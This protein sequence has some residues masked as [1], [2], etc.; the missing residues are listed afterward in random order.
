MYK[1]RHYPGELEQLQSLPLEGKIRLT[2]LRIRQ[3]LG[4][5]DGEAYISFSGGKDSTVLLHIARKVSPAITAVFCDTGLEYPEIREFVKGFEN[6]VWLKPQMNF[7]QVIDTYGYPIV[8]KETA[9]RIYQIRHYNLTDTYRSKLLGKGL[10][11]IP[12]KWRCLINAP[13]EISHK[14]C[15]I[16]KKRPFHRYEKET[17]KHGINATMASESISRKSSWLLYGCNAFDAKTP[18]SR[19]MS[20]W[21]E[22]DVLEYLIK[23][24]VQYCSLYGDIIGITP[25]GATVSMAELQKMLKELEIP[26]EIKLQTTALTRTGC[27]FCGFG[28]HLD[29]QPNR[30]QKMAESHP[31]QYQFCMKPWAE[32]GLGLA[33]VLEYIHVVH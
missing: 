22:R 30:F 25:D 19:P 12:Q 29:K 20:F 13:F 33:E 3:W 28:C 23:Y 2:K 14:C 26:K 31:K 24:D 6:V 27:M 17:G 21:T 18:L 15:D 8:S 32:G 11:A 4:A 7:R 9:Q 1:H 5:F 16:M 10:G